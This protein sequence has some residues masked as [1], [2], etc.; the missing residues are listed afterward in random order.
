MVSRYYGIR[1]YLTNKIQYI[2]ITHN[3][4]L[5]HALVITFIKTWLMLVPVLLLVVAMVLY[6]FKKLILILL[7]KTNFTI[8]HIYR[9]EFLVQ[10]LLKPFFLFSW[11]SE[12]EISGLFSLIF[13]SFFSSTASALIL[14]YAEIQLLKHRKNEAAT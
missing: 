7:I 8:F 3:L 13:C 11:L 4:E 1:S 14:L 9:N 12:T 10:P 6:M 5:R 2:S